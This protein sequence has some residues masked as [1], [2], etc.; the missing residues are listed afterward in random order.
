MEQLKKNNLMIMQ[1]QIRTNIITHY[2]NIHQTLQISPQFNA[3][4]TYQP[5]LLVGGMLAVSVACKTVRECNTDEQ[6]KNT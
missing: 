4:L 2:V 6:T 5:V 3:D 1:I